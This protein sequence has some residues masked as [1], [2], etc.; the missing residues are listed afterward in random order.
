MEFIVSRENLIKPL[1]Q[2]CAVLSSRPPMP[3]LHNILLEVKGGTLFITGT[4]AEVE[5]TAQVTLFSATQDGVAT[6]PGKKFLDL[7]RSLPDDSEI[8]ASFEQDRAIIRSGRSK[9]NLSTLP[10]EDYPTLADWL[11]NVSFEMAQST[12]LNLINATHFAMASQDAR[13][14]LNGMKLETDGHLF[15]AIATDGHRLARCEEPVSTELPKHDV[16]L[17]RKAVLE[18]QRSLDTKGDTVM[19]QIGTNNLRVNLGKMMFTSKL[20]D[21]ICNN[22]KY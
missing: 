7:C 8:T 10:A 16:I 4:D 3:V 18:L 9:F 21:V 6:I 20:L 22:K 5:L 11:P 14:F 13:Y 2:V 19:V 1:A 17:P 15:A 12:L